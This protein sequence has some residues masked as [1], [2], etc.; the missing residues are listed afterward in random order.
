MGTLRAKLFWLSF[1]VI[2][3]AVFMTGLLLHFKYQSVFSGLQRDR[4]LMVAGEIA[5]IAHKSLSM[6]QDLRE[7]SRMQDVLERSRKIDPILLAVAVTAPNAQVLYTTDPA[8]AGSQ[9]SASALE[10][11][12]RTPAAGLATGLSASS[13]AEVQ[14]ALRIRNSFDQVAGYVVVRYSRQAEVQAMQVFAR[15]LWL[16]CGAV[17]SLFTLLLY[18][19]L[20][21]LWRR[22]EVD[23]AAAAAWLASTEAGADET[24]WRAAMPESL[25]PALK[26]ELQIIDTQLAAAHSQI[27]LAQAGLAP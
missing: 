24:A 18:T 25:S 9:P 17:F 4:V 12:V 13:R 6:G 20:T 7:L 2:G 19:V 8:P 11:L 27:K 21:A 15:R 3:F 23:L 1:W 22:T 14:V 16:C 5:D 10:Q 26:R